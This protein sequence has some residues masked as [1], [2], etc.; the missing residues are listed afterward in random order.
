MTTQQGQGK[1]LFTL[2]AG[3]A[4][5]QVRK[6]WRLQPARQWQCSHLSVE[7]QSRQFG[8]PILLRDQPVKQTT[9]GLRFERSEHARPVQRRDQAAPQHA[10]ER[11]ACVGLGNPV[12]MLE[13]DVGLADHLVGRQQLG[14]VA[15]DQRRQRTQAAL[16]TFFRVA[17]RQPDENGS[18]NP[19]ACPL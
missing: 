9:A 2:R 14:V 19:V 6:I 17:R 18:V 4:C 1:A 3:R 12:V 10:R 15:L 7:R 11:R 8:T 16:E 5:K 13:R